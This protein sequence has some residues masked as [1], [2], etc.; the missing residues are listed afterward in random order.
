MKL[1]KLYKTLS[2]FKLQYDQKKIQIS[3]IK[4]TLIRLFKYGKFRWLGTKHLVCI[5]SHKK[6]FIKVGSDL[7]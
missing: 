6:A 7:R 3:D 4:N 1:L 2:L 5:L